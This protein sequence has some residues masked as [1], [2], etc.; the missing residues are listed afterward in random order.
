MT[1]SDTNVSGNIFWFSCAAINKIISTLPSITH[2]FRPQFSFSR[3]K[4]RMLIQCL[5]LLNSTID[6]R[7]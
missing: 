3:A 5:S 6:Q 1:P 2:I 7:R 4:H